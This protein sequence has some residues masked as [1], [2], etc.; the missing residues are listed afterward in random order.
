MARF[1]AVLF[2]L[3]SVVIS[4]FAIPQLINYQGQLTSPSG[5]PL[6][7]TVAMSFA[8][9]DS[10]SGGTAVWTETHPSV[11]VTDGLFSVQLGSVTSLPDVFAVNRWL[12][13]TVGGDTELSPREQLISVAYAYRVGTVGGA[14]GGTVTGNITADSVITGGVRF[15][16]GSVQTSAGS[17]GDLTP[18]QQ[19]ADTATYD[20]TKTYVTSQGYVNEAGSQQDSDTNSWDATKTYVTSQGYV[21]EA[22]SQQDSDTNS[23]DA[24]MTYVTSQGYVNEAGSQ[25]DSDTNSWDATMTYVTSQGY[26]NEAGSQ[27]DSVDCTPEA[28]QLG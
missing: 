21:N 12:G 19:K 15:G 24:T 6:D 5:T 20:A 28:G 7:T 10:V 11:T 13:V 22:G 1:Q 2:A 18:Y 25:Q 8:L 27:Q 9:Y 26:V 14:T 16:D 23:W 4:A 17:G 3:L